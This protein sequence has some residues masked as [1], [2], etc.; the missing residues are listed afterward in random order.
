MHVAARLFSE[1]LC[2]HLSA[3]VRQGTNYLKLAARPAE[4][5]TDVFPPLLAII[6]IFLNYYYCRWEVFTFNNMSQAGRRK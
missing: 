6:R 5:K 1:G 4:I 2:S 3:L